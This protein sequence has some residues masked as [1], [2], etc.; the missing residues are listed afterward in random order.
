MCKLS[1]VRTDMADERVDEYK[2]V[3]NLTEI[4]GVKVESK[5]EKL[6]TSFCA[7]VT[8]VDILNENGKRALDKEVGK[9]VTIEI[10]EVEFLPDE[11]REK[12]TK[13]LGKEIA[14]Q[15]NIISQK[16]LKSVL[17]VGLG[18]IYVTPDALGPKV[19]SGINV[20]RHII[21]YAKEL[22]TS[23]VNEISAI[24]PGVMG[25]TGIETG[26][27]IKSVVNEVK[28]DV[29]IAIDSL[30]SLSVSRVGRTIQLG[31]TGI[32]PGAGIGNK[33]EAINMKTLGVP[34]IAIG[35]PTVVESAVIVN[36]CL[37]LFIQ[38]L[39][40]ESKSNEYL[41]KLKEQDN[42]EEIKEALVPNDY[43]MIVTPKEIDDLIEKMKDVIAKRDKLCSVKQSKF[44]Q[45]IKVNSIL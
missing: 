40:N 28:P 15:V 39:Q 4:D 36:E 14:E 11:D 30:A 8:T 1:N 5:E 9:Y 21:K 25:T 33:R 37:D 2:K 23:P 12:L 19:V 38:K 34:V 26:E 13:I 16:K 24:A 35:V 32:T 43:N 27:I 44:K 3:N 41:N 18:N 31:N 42:Y 17:V 20:T 7:K 29:I 10:P 22:L 6:S 45:N